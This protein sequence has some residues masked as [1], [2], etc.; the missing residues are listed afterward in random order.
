MLQIN[1]I[2]T[3]KIKLI[4]IKDGSSDILGVAQVI[5]KSGGDEPFSCNDEKVFRYDSIEARTIPNTYDIE[6]YMMKFYCIV[7]FIF[8]ANIFNFAA[9]VCV[10]LSYMNEVNLK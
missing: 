9:L 1:I 10:M 8:I 3:I 7:I 2:N 4:I 6:A 5:N